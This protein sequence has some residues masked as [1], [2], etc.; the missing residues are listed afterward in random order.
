MNMFW[1]F[2]DFLR[3]SKDFF[4]FSVTFL[5]DVLDFCGFLRSYGIS[6]NTISSRDKKKSC[7]NL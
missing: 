5:E 2:R 4:G 6:A 3:L 7:L 1:D